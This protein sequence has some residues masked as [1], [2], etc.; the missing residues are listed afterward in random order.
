MSEAGPLHE[1]GRN[2]KGESRKEMQRKEM[3]AAK[4]EIEFAR[5]ELEPK[6]MRSNNVLQPIEKQGVKTRQGVYD[7]GIRHEIHQGIYS[8]EVRS[9]YPMKTVHN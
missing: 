7:S 6:L 4:K 8:G 3:E 2:N 5:K 1:K 9:S